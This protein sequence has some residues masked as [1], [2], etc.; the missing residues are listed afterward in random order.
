MSLNLSDELASLATTSLA[1]TVCQGDI[2]QLVPNGT[3]AHVYEDSKKR[4]KVDSG[5]VDGGVYRSVR[6]KIASTEFL[7]IIDRPTDRLH[8][9]SGVLLGNTLRWGQA[10]V[11]PGLGMS[12]RDVPTRLLAGPRVPP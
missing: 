1:R 12:L 7:K 5:I 10:V 3:L 6:G 4:T 2:W 9:R 11:A 8:P